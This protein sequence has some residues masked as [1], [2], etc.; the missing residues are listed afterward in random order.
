[1]NTEIINSIRNALLKCNNV[2]KYIQMEIDFNNQHPNE[3]RAALK[4]IS[5]SL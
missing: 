3:Y 1:M 4:S 5:D 2:A